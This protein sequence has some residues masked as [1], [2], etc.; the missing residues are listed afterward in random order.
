MRTLQNH[1]LERGSAL[2]SVIIAGAIMTVILLGTTQM[3]ERQ[4]N[5]TSFLEDR[6]SK[7]D[8]KGVLIGKLS[9]ANACSETISGL[10]V[11]AEQVL[12]Q[13]RE[14][15]GSAAY[16][17]SGSTLNSFDKLNLTQLKLINVSTPNAPNESG[18][19]KIRVSLV[20]QRK[21]GGPQELEPFD[22]SIRVTTDNS[23]ILTTCKAYG[24][25]SGV[26]DCGTV[27]EGDTRNVPS[28]TATVTEFCINGKWLA[29]NSTPPPSTGGEDVNVCR[30]PYYWNGIECMRDG[31]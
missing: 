12:Q 15:D 31:R 23:K 11:R 24:D 28:G 27:E 10:Q 20:R 2:I 30:R 19:M 13:I 17:S 29:L 6:L 8:F 7:I 5:S 18:T 16:S 21:G 9:D 1:H 14:K 4:G 26:G 22:V 25:G 3:I